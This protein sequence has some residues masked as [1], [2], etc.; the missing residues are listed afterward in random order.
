MTSRLDR[1]FF[2]LLSGAALT[3]CGT[4]LLP[5]AEEE[6]KRARAAKKKKKKKKRSKTRQIGIELW[7]GAEQQPGTPFPT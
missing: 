4:G 7:A 2:L 3:G 1:R 5:D 6:K